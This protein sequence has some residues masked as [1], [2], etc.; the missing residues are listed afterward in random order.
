M[1]ADRQPPDAPPPPD[2]EPG[3]P[4]STPG[5]AVWDLGA[6][7]DALDAQADVA[8]RVGTSLR[9]FA[10]AQVKHLQLHIQHAVSSGQLRQQLEAARAEVAASPIMA[11][12]PAEEQETAVLGLLLADLAKTAGKVALE[13]ATKLT[14][15]ANNLQGQAKAKREMAAKL[16]APDAS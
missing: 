4:P 12:A 7:A 14:A 1:A 15:T 6:E 16:G 11:G 2:T 10:A 9:G 5:T 3:V 8:A 13:A